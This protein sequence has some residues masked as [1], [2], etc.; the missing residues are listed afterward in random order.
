MRSSSCTR[1]MAYSTMSASISSICARRMCVCVLGFL[2]YH[3]QHTGLCSCACCSHTNCPVLRCAA[4]QGLGGGDGCGDLYRGPL[5]CALWGKACQ[6]M[7]PCR[8]AASTSAR[9]LA[10]GQ[11]SPMPGGQ[12]MYSEM[13]YACRQR[14]DRWQ[15]HDNR[16]AD[17]RTQQAAWI[18][19]DAMTRRSAATHM[20]HPN[21]ARV[22]AAVL[23]LLCC[24]DLRAETRDVQS[25]P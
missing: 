10:L 24:L 3:Q 12:S 7:T 13:R 1:S 19:S 17:A 5:T 6:V 22:A 4:A 15:M 18:A 25:D 16:R 8:M 21:V 2:H 9:A 14:C 11:C 20:C 23:Q